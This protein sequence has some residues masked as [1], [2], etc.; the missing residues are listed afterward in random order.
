MTPRR[1]SKK[2][3]ASQRA[4]ESQFASLNRYLIFH[5]RWENLQSASFSL[6][7]I[8][9]KIFCIQ[10]RIV[11]KFCPGSARNRDSLTAG[12]TPESVY[13]VILKWID[14]SDS[15]FGFSVQKNSPGS[16]WLMGAMKEPLLPR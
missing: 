3:E 16:V 7:K 9:I 12:L 5:C 1:A 11:S 2:V 15:E 4:L 8:I 14:S 6:V 10:V 13:D